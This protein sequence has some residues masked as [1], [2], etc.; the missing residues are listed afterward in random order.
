MIA[1][2][3]LPVGLPA[4]YR[5]RPVTDADPEAISELINACSLAEI[6][7]PVATPELIRSNWV[8][9]GFDRARHARAVVDSEGALAAY[10]EYANT[11]P[12]YTVP[13]A[14]SM[15]HPDHAGR[16]IGTAQLRLIES[17][18]RADLGMAPPEARVVLRAWAN[19][20]A[21]ASRALL[22][23][24]GFEPVRAFYKML[25]DLDAPPAPPVWP[26]GVR[27]RA[28][29]PERDSRSV[30]AAM[31]A[32]FA[33][34][35]DAHDIPYDEWLL[36]HRRADNYDPTLWFLAVPA[37]GPDGGILGAALCRPQEYTDPDLGWI[38]QLFVR[39]DWRRRG[40]GQ[41]LLR[42]AF[43]VYHARGKQRVGLTVDA[44]NLS[45]AAR[46]YE[47]VGMRVAR[48]RIVYD[49]LLREGSPETT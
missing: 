23:A 34:H 44:D 10:L 48:Q 7:A 5:L 16:G 26:E 36:V 37:A 14:F 28:Y 15:V 30:H 17:W 41:A 25:I 1:N 40:L 19:H 11:E 27:R 20:Q 3:D 38:S 42:Q 32:A 21:G 13:A 49:K 22:E 47:A 43:G 45:G 46:L 4:G 8:M 31:N 18:A 6:G 39:A 29:D 9:P 24:E 35:W 2:D 12:P 33:D